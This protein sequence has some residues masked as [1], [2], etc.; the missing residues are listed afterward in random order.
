M[1][2]GPP[3]SRRAGCPAQAWEDRESTGGPAAR[4]DTGEACG[5]KRLSIPGHL[6]GQHRRKCRN[7]CTAKAGRPQ[8]VAGQRE[9]LSFLQRPT[10]SAACPRRSPNS[11]ACRALERSLLCHHSWFLPSALRSRFPALPP[12][13]RQSPH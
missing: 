5:R 3:N 6:R 1:P 8:A 11:S 2:A 13:R 7:R 10:G 4:T 9:E 12:S